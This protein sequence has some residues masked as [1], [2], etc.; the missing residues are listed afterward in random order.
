MLLFP[1]AAMF[2][3]YSVHKMYSSNLYVVKVFTYLTS[4]QDPKLSDATVTPTSHVLE[5]AMLLLS[6][7]GHWKVRLYVTFE[8]RK[9]HTKFHQNPSSKSRS[10]LCGQTGGHYHT[11]VRSFRTHRANIAH[12]EG[13][14]NGQTDRM[15]IS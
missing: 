14:A 15:V 6:I 12:K 10:G 9:A 3:F 13:Q 4:F 7:V 5:T 1:V 2:F 8:W 11:N